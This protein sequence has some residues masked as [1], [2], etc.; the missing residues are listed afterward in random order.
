MLN[1]ELVHNIILLMYTKALEEMYASV[2]RADKRNIFP[3]YAVTKCETTQFKS[4]KKK[5]FE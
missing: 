2:F 3:L 4:R 1:L 5:K